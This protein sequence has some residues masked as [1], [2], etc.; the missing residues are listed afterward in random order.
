M[1]GDFLDG[2]TGSSKVYSLS[3]NSTNSNR[4]A[5]MRGSIVHSKNN[6]ILL[7]NVSNFYNFN[8]EIVI[9]T[10]ILHKY[11][12]I[13]RQRTMDYT[14]EKSY[15]YRP[16]YVSQVLY[17]TTDLWYLLLFLNYMKKP[18]EFTKETIKVFDPSQLDFLND[19]IE[20]ERPA[21]KKIDSPESIKRELV[22]DLN[23]PSK[24]IL[25]SDYDRKIPPVIK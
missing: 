16:E 5:D 10:S 8:G 2:L 18:D 15:F 17:S 25:S 22:R 11:D 21:I 20:K 6:K 24:R 3:D 7:D 14:I 19:I 13:L 4:Y 23:S 9:S 12:N 1:S